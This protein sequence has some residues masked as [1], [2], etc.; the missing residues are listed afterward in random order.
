M[1][2]MI[3]LFVHLKWM[4]GR[5]IMFLVVNYY[6]GHETWW[7]VLEEVTVLCFPASLLDS[8]TDWNALSDLIGV[9]RSHELPGFRF[10]MHIMADCSISFRLNRK[11]ERNTNWW[12]PNN[13]RTSVIQGTK[14]FKK[15]Q[16]STQISSIYCAIVEA[17]QASVFRDRDFSECII[18]FPQK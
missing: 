16:I 17:S 14:H 3:F 8:I 10:F 6:D 2:D 9:L 12:R 4:D 5:A 15:S 13:T 18:I 1:N 7:F 11:R